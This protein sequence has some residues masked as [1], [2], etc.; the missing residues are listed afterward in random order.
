MNTLEALIEHKTAELEDVNLHYVEAGQVGQPL[1]VLL[2][3]FPEYWYSWRCQIP[4]LV[5]AGYRVIAPDMRGYNLSSKPSGAQSYTA[6]YL[7]RDVFAL[8]QQ[9]GESQAAV[10]GH[11]WGAA[12]AWYFAMRYPDALTRLAIINGPHPGA[13]R[14]QL[15]FNPQQLKR[16]WY[17]FAF[18]LPRY[19]ERLFRENN[20]ERLRRVFRL[21][22]IRHDAFST[23]EIDQY[24]E[25]MARPGALTAAIN[26]YRAA[27]RYDALK[28]SVPLRTVTAPTL[29]LWG[30][31]DKYLGAHVPE[32]SA[33]WVT[34]HTIVRIDPAS[35][36]A[37][38]DR[39]KLINSQLIDFFKPLI[40]SQA[41]PRPAKQA[42][43]QPQE[44]Q[45][46]TAD[47]SP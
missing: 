11:D 14:W 12:V 15:F 29:T 8:I 28:C 40:G 46:V 44:A 30:Q 37:Q 22:P 45:A 41:A 39:P 17:I 42:T 34:D 18:Q 10:V 5:E 3:G 20:W 25:A 27:L 21:D 9:C 35:H 36:W 26:Y 47:P 38:V 7:S 23:A 33:S 2:H 6:D 13:F 43:P 32:L 16:S 4:A 24:V 19:P 1:V 31:Q